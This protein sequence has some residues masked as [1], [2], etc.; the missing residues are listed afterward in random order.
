MSIFPK[1]RKWINLQ[2]VLG[3][4]KGCWMDDKGCSAYTP[5]LRVQTAP[6]GRC[7]YIIYIYLYDTYMLIFSLAWQL[8][9][10]GSVLPASF[11]DRINA[12]AFPGFGA[13][14]AKLCL[15]RGDFAI[16]MHFMYLHHCTKNGHM[17]THLMHESMKENAWWNPRFRYRSLWKKIFQVSTLR[18]QSFS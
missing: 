9:F 12:A 15:S 7:W 17:V 14:F 10:L 6:F 2:D 5:S 11:S 8:F 18:G 1:R 13:F 4:C 3:S 16:W